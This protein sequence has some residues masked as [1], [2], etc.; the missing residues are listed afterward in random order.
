MAT[1]KS[2]LTEVVKRRLGY[3]VIK[4]EINDTQISDHINYARQKYIKWAVGNATQEYYFTLALSAGQILYDMPPGLTEVIG[5]RATLYG[6]GINT[7]FTIEN[8]LY[9]LG[10]YGHIESGMSDSWSLVGYHLAR[11]LLETLE[12]YTHDEYNF[13]YHKY[14]NQL[15]INPMPPSGAIAT[16]HILIRGFFIE[17][18]TPWSTDMVDLGYSA[19]PQQQDL[20]GEGWIL[21]YVSALSKITLGYIRNKFSNF[22]S[23]GNIG[24]S[25][26]GDSMISEGKE[27]KERLE[28]ELRLEEA[29]EGYGIEVG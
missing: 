12:R 10:F 21:D 23:L 17:N 11:D 28:E 4:V 19:D 1:T 2:Q 15:E 6:G 24:L 25:L 7:L 5:Y 29:W 9:N 8:Y 26:D 20:Y 27:E 16:H 14:T 13:H 18:A 3:P 22:A